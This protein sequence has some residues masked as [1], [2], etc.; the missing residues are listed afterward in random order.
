MLDRR[1]K[2]YGRSRRFRTYGYGGRSLR[3]FL[4][5]KVLLVVFS[6][7]EAEMCFYY[8]GA[9]LDWIRLMGIMIVLSFKIVKFTYLVGMIAGKIFYDIW[10]PLFLTYGFGYGLRPKAEVF[11]G[12]T[13]G[14][15]RRWK[16]R[17]RSN[18]AKLGC[19]LL[20]KEH[21]L[22]LSFLG[23]NNPPLSSPKFGSCL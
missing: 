5:P 6:K 16:L 17:L 12:W 13:F 21:T 14:Y 11:Q 7:M 15:G 1:P 23:P 9:T 3:Q 18:T 8:T 19:A 4:R 10:F 2:F 22:Y 20:S